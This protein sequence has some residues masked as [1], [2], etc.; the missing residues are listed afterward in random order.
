V[1]AG[2]RETGLVLLEHYRRAFDRVV[3]GVFLTRLDGTVEAANEAACRMLGRSE[4]ELC[5][6]GRAG[7]VDPSDERL[8]PALEEKTSM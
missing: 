4:E 7:I 5:R 3:D 2:V 1:G 8:A 6:I